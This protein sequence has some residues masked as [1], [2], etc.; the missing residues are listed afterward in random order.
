MTTQTQSTQ[1]LAIWLSNIPRT[2]VISAGTITIRRASYPAVLYT[3]DRDPLPGARNQNPYTM[4]A[5]YVLGDLPPAYNRRKSTAFRLP[6]DDK[7]WY[8]ASYSTQEALEKHPEYYPFGSHFLLCPW[9]AEF[10]K[11]DTYEK[12]TYQRVD[13]KT[14]FEED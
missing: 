9:E 5:I 7:D 4:T 10:P 8:I 1:D 3:Q 13:I 14:D 12:H 6:N 11:I 2:K